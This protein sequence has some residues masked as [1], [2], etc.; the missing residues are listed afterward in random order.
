MLL[1]QN[2]KGNDIQMIPSNPTNSAMVPDSDKSKATFLGKKSGANLDG[3][4]SGPLLGHLSTAQPRVMDT[5]MFLVEE[6]SPMEPT[7]GAK[8]PRVHLPVQVVSG[9]IDSTSFSQFSSADLQ[10]QVRRS[11]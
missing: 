7:E 8:R 2:K 9:E 1:A 5:T 3:L 6:E 10:D 4:N 11:S